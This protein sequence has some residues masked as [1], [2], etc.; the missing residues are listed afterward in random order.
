MM[1]FHGTARAGERMSRGEPL[2]EELPAQVRRLVEELRLHKDRSGLSLA[3][4][5]TKTAYGTSTWYR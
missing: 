3:V 5:S 2:P 1:R 4:L